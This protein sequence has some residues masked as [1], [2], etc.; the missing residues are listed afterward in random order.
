MFVERYIS[1]VTGRA[2]SSKNREEE[3]YRSFI[4]GGE[5]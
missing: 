4:S 5:A 3:G 1:H 2:D